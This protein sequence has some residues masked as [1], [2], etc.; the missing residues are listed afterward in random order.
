MTHLRDTRL[1]TLVW[2]LCLLV[3][4][5][6]VLHDSIGRTTQGF[7]AYYAASRLLVTGHFG[8]WVYEDAWFMRYV[9]DITGTR[10]LEIFGPN[11]PT[12]ALLA[13]PLG[14]SA[15]AAYPRLYAAWLLWGLT[16]R[17]MFRDRRPERAGAV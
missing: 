6:Y 9:Q 13:L 2:V 11:T 3:L 15:L 17:E 5:A 8:P 12:M 7:I 1:L 4:G 14:W 10:V 16:V